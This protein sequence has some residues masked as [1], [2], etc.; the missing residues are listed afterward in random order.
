MKIAI[1]QRPTIINGFEY[2][3]TARG[4]YDLLPHHTLM[5]VTNHSIQTDIDFDMLIISGGENT[6]ERNVVEQHYFELAQEHSKPVFGVC[7]GAFFINEYFGGT[8]KGIDNHQN[9][10]H[11]VF[12]DGSLQ[13]VNSYHS[14][15]IDTLSKR[16]A[17]VSRDTSSN[18]EAFKHKKLPIWGVVW[19]PERMQEPVLPKDLKELLLG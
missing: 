9:A 17:V 15:A 1:T 6:A 2:D 19:H 16:L 8:N 11:S 18:I 5:P 14:L 7:H 13:T 12:L 3:A 10:E 4:W